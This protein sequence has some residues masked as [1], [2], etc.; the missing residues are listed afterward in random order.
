MNN[1]LLLRICLLEENARH[2]QFSQTISHYTFKANGEPTIGLCRKGRM[3]CPRIGAIGGEE[4]TIIS[5]TQLGTSDRKQFDDG[6][7]VDLCQ[8]NLTGSIIGN[9]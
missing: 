7:C 9:I 2:E 4:P 1:L 6:A 5:T 8:A 3:R